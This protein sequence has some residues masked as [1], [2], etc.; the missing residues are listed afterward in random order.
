MKT[1]QVMIREEGFLQRTSDG[2]FNATKLIEHWNTV[3]SDKKQL[4]NYMKIQGTN[5]YILQLKKEG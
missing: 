5:D 1:N 4:G 2:Y 3:N